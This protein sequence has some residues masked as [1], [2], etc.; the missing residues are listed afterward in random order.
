MVRP[1]TLT[2]AVLRSARLKVAPNPVIYEMS[3]RNSTFLS[4]NWQLTTDN[5]LPCATPQ[6]AVQCRRRRCTDTAR[7]GLN[8][9]GRSQTPWLPEEA[10]VAQPEYRA[11]AGCQS[12]ARTVAHEAGPSSQ[13]L[14]RAAQ[15][16]P[17][18]RRAFAGFVPHPTP[19][20]AEERQ[21]PSRLIRIAETRPYRRDRKS[22]R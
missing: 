2:F 1:K 19:G 14:R 6:I 10:A 15:L 17:S 20:F 3:L 5:R 13:C 4:D 9:R 7:C 22:T 18:A 12:C 8:L 21:S 16:L 11:R